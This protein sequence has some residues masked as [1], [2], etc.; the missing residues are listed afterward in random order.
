MPEFDDLFDDD[1]DLSGSD[2]VKQLRNALKAEKKARKDEQERLARYERENR[3]RSLADV[4]KDKGLDT[5][6][7]KLYPAD[8]DTSPEAVDKWLEDYGDLFGIERRTSAADDAT[9]AAAAALTGASAAAPPATQ[10]F[11]V[12]SLAAEMAAA[13]SEE[14]FQAVLAKAGFAIT[15]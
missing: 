1:A 2:L 12:D 6:V 9:K 13:N 11:D 15:E 5:K 8:A 14:E 7:A 10:A 4:L 3:T